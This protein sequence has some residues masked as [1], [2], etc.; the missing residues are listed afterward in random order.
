MALPRFGTVLTAMVTPFS[1]DGSVNFDVASQIA[2]FIVEQGC[3]GL[4]IAGSTG[5]GSA[6]SNDEKMDLF[7]C[8]A[9]AVNVPVLAGTTSSNTAESVALTSRVAATG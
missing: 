7:S 5:E 6:L 4:V 3:D 9:Q 8:V 2:K 1:P